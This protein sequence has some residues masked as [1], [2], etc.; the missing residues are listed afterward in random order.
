[1]HKQTGRGQGGGELLDN[2]LVVHTGGLGDFL[3]T[4]PALRHLGS[5]NRLCLLGRKERLELAVAAGI[6]DAAEDMDVVDFDSVF[7]GPSPVLRSFLGRFRGAVVWMKDDGTIRR[8]F[9]QA[10]IQ[11]VTSFPGKPPAQWDRHASEYYLDCLGLGPAPPLCMDI[12]PADAALDTVI[13]PG[14]GSPRKNWPLER[15]VAVAEAFEA[16]GRRVTWSLG[17]AEE[18]VRLPPGH[19]V[20]RDA[21]LI[22]LARMLGA[23]RFY[24]GND[25]GV[26]HLAAAVGC[27]TVAIFG[28]TDPKV[29]A[30]RG[31]HVRV[32]GGAP[33]PN[34]SEVIAACLDMAHGRLLR[35]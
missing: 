26:T 22:E 21:S 33:W 7:S 18:G 2:A 4:C 34:I 29:W 9:G 13:H 11:D 20:V 3:L 10:G 23:A 5:E 1:M 24:L 12:G 6:A 25:S 30:P 19:C 15:F 16:G 31:A 28:P 14:S 17:P 27:P 32:V 8:G 35:A